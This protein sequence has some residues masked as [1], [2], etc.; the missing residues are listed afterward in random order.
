MEKIT[1]KDYVENVVRTESNNFG[2]IMN[3]CQN[4]NTI[5]LLHSGIGLATESSEFLDNLKKHI[6]YGK[7]LDLVNAKEEIGDIL[8]YVG[9]ACDVLNISLDE[10]MTANINKLKARYPEKFTKEKAENRNL[11]KERTI[12]EGEWLCF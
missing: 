3:R 1:S 9:I 4:P 5:R 10:V 2:N 6:Y 7:D 12:L 8:W 11:E